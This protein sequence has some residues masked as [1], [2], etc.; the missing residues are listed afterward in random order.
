[1]TCDLTDHGLDLHAREWARVILDD[2]DPGDYSP[3]D[4]RNAA[5]DAAHE[6]ADSSEWVIYTGRALWLCAVCNTDAGEEFMADVGAP[7][8]VT[9]DSVA[10]MVAYGELRHRIECEIDA[11]LD[12]E[13]D[14]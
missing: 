4:R 9:L 2:L 6:A 12:E 7:D 5:F 8:P 13:S 10:T 11:I 1:M 14:Q 3:D